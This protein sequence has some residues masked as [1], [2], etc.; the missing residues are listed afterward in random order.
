MEEVKRLFDILEY[1]KTNYPDKPNVL[2]GKF[3]ESWRV[4]DIDEY[5]RMT[6]AVSY[7]FIHLGIKEGD[8]VKM[9]DWEFE[10][11]E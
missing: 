5:I 6:N 8:I 9:L 11:Y 4:Y 3:D 2:S 7:A 1:R 10:W